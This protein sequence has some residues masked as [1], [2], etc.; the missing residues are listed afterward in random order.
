MGIR[1]SSVPNMGVAGLV[2]M[3][4]LAVQPPAPAP[5]QSIGAPAAHTVPGPIDTLRLSL[6]AARDLALRSNPDLSAARLDIDVARGEL[7]QAGVLLRANPEAEVLTRGPGTEVG[8]SQEVEV[9]GQRS[10]RRAA[11]RAGLERARAGVTDV[12]RLTLGD[13]HRA[14]YRLV[15]ADRRSALADEVRALNERLVDV[16]QRQ[17]GAGEISRLEFNLAVV[18][19]G[20]SRGRALAAQRAREEVASDLR[21]LLGLAPAT[22]LVPVV[23]TGLEPPLPD[24]AWAGVGEYS[25]AIPLD[26]DSLTALALARRPDVLERAAAVRQASANVSLARRE[27]FP[28]LVLRATSEAV[29]GSGTRELRPGIGFTLPLLNRNQGEVAARR[30]AAVQAEYTRTRVTALVRVEVARA[31]ASYRTAAAEAEVLKTTVLVPARENRD[32]LEIA[33]REG[34]V[35]LPVLLL[36]RNQVID[37]ELQFWDAWLAEREALTDLLEATGETVAGWTP[38]GIENTPPPRL[39]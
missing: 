5:A 30:A 11:A 25:A 1:G 20:R 14:F 23:D 33:Y 12:A 18:E 8:I 29:E 38:D 35:G 13:V 2:V 34:K 7:R 24:S 15:A 9:A 32:L 10:A 39:K 17:L 28:N 31:V 37:A 6:A 22:P 26:V 27:A 19:F 16:A 3:V 21:R 36:I 4:A